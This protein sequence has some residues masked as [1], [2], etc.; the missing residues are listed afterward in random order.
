MVT[1]WLQ[2]IET[3]ETCLADP[4]VEEAH[5]ARKAAN[6]VGACAYIN[7]IE[8]RLKNKQTKKEESDFFA[9]Q[10]IIDELYEFY[11]LNFRLPTTFTSIDYASVR[12][13]SCLN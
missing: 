1:T 5:A 9:D 8:I 3:C 4:I 13:S 10:G 11:K 12:Y 2:R 7:G 6:Y